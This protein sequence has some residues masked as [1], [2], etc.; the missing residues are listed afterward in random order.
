MIFSK[1]FQ[2]AQR[3]DPKT[4]KPLLISKLKMKGN[5]NCCYG[6][7]EQDWNTN[8]IFSVMDKERPKGQG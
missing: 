1:T 4:S 5:Y 6:D 7:W 2:M 3:D 8:E